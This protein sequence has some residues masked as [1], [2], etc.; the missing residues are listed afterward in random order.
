MAD[1][2]GSCPSGGRAATVT[3]SRR[4]PWSARSRAGGVLAAIAIAGLLVVTTFALGD[5]VLSY[6]GSSQAAGA[7]SPFRFIDGGNY[8]TASAEGFVSL[9][10]PTTQQ[11]GFAATLHGSDGAD[12]TYALDVLELQARSNTTAGWSL[13]LDVTKALSGT[14]VNAAYAFYCT[15]APTGVSVTGTALASGTDSAGDP[16]AVYAPTCAG[17]QESLPLT[18]I[19]SGT[20]VTIATTTFGTTVL[21]LSFATDVASAGTGTITPASVVLEAT[22]P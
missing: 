1:P 15:L 4:P 12:G 20:A 3:G 13:A 22:S 8:A 5:V 6:E 2:A 14:G 19:G 16:W 9:T 7:V 10:F 21:Y 18:G 11:V 17:T